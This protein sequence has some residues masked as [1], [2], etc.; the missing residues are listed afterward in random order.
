MTEEKYGEKVA[1]LRGELKLSQPDLHEMSGV[2]LRTIQ[3]VENNP[4]SRPQRKTRLALNKAL[5]IEGT[6]QVEREEW[7]D[8]VSVFLDVIGVWLMTMEQEE[9]RMAIH[10]LTRHIWTQR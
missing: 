9:R 6:A 7:P 10:D 1:R 5:G 3:N 2:P 4:D 8:D